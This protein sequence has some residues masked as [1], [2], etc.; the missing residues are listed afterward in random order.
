MV[1]CLTKVSIWDL[2]LCEQIENEY[3]PDRKALGAAGQ[4]YIN[5]AAKMAVGLN[6]GVPWVMCKEDDAPDPVVSDS[7]SSPYLISPSFSIVKILILFYF[8]LFDL[9]N[10]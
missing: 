3:G 1:T 7:Q 8:S 9:G 6:T 2:V 4:A 10:R 5:W